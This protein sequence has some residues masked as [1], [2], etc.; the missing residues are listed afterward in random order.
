MVTL[1]SNPDVA[2]FY[3]E[4]TRYNFLLIGVVKFVADAD[5]CVSES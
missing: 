1:A 5:T 3:G 2:P 4:M